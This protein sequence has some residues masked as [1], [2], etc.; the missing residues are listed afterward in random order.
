MF[1]A[2]TF[3]GRETGFAGTGLLGVGSSHG[4]NVTKVLLRIR[5]SYSTF[6]LLP[7]IIYIIGVTSCGT[8]AF[9]T[10][11]ETICES[12]TPSPGYDH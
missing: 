11:D 5:F 6:N 9:V 3:V 12:R 7:Y 8:Q 4:H 2:S 1:F 10:S